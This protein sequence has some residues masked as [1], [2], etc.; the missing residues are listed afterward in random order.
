VSLLSL[1]VHLLPHLDVTRG[2]PAS[3]RATH[4][5]AI[6]RGATSDAGV[7]ASGSGRAA[8][9]VLMTRMNTHSGLREGA[10][11]D[12]R[13]LL[14]ERLG[15]GSVGDVWRAK[16]LELESTVAVKLLAPRFLT[17]P[18]KERH[19]E[20]FLREASLPG[21]VDCPYVVRVMECRFS[22]ELGP[23]IVMEMLDGLDLF[24]HL[25]R[26]GTLEIGRAAGLLAQL[27]VALEALHG[28]EVFHRDVK[29][30][31][32]VVSLR[33]GRPC[34]TLVDFSLAR[35]ARAPA[36]EVQGSIVGTPAYLSP[37]RVRGSCRG[38][39]QSD[40][41]ALAVVA[42]QCLVGRVPFDDRTL[43]TLREALDGGAF[44]PP[45]AFRSDVSSGIDAWF[46][47]AFSPSPSERFASAPEM[48][49][50]IVEACSP[51]PIESLAGDESTLNL[52]VA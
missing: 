33:S 35:D 42:Y 36:H 4:P 7:M 41:W 43:G 6:V 24:E 51:F 34:A 12:G 13:V 30:E 8:G 10:V 3:A 25:T 16:H 29:P 40:L 5:F 28:A 45:S 38:D 21:R 27:C 23:Y 52:C 44:A 9:T 2:N 47:R 17:G 14:E 37:E 1:C 46:R 39:A 32:V 15:E 50:A 48:R 18:S 26:R 49:E 11:I 22:L 20:A 31:N 19:V